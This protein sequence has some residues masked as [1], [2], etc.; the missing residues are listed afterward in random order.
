[1]R[2]RPNVLGVLL[3]LSLS[4]AAPSLQAAE[5]LVFVS[6]AFRRSIPVADLDHL[7]E[8]GQARG[9]LAD[10][11]KIGRQNPE[12]VAR[13]L[14]QKVTLPLVLTSRLLSTRIGN[15]ILQR[16]AGIFAPLN[17]P[18]AGVPALRSALIIG[19][20]NGNGTLTP[21]GFLRAYPTNE[22]AI[23][24]PALLSLLGKTNSI[25]ELVRFFSESPLDG[26]REGNEQ[27]ATSAPGSSPATTPSQPPDSTPGAKGS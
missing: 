17:A 14:N 25:A 9:L 2:I 5:Q 6:G 27:P 8:T 11:L 16:L 22:L 19:I 1:M 15:A 24:I 12:D 23:N 4:T 10:V 20:H 21:T 7:A 13:L 3:G 26:L 18:S